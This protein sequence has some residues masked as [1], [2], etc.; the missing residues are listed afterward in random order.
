MATQINDDTQ[1]FKQFQDSDDFRRWLTDTSSNLT[2]R[3]DFRK[4][5]LRVILLRSLRLRL[6]SAF[7]SLPHLLIKKWTEADR[8]LFLSVLFQFD[9]FLSIYSQGK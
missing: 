1:L 5:A 4:A 8:L 6:Q 2:Y 7:S 9:I 3:N